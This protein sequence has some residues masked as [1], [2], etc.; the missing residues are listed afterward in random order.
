MF[1]MTSQGVRAADGDMAKVGL[2]YF[3]VGLQPVG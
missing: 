2:N 3:V 1:L